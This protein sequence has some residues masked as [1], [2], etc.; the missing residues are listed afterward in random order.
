[1]LFEPCVEGDILYPHLPS[2]FHI[3]HCRMQITNPQSVDGQ[4]H[5][6][7]YLYG[8]CMGSSMHNYIRLRA[9]IY[10]RQAGFKGVELSAE[11]PHDSKG[12]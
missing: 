3:A 8:W 11:A 6:Y 12:R 10:A 7:G 9:T 2:T 1:V 5:L 4:A